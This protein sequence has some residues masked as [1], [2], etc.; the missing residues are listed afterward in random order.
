MALKTF[1][2]VSLFSNCGAG[3]TGFARAG[4]RFA[5]MAELD[6]RRLEVCQ[7][8]HPTSVTVPGDLRNTW[9]NVVDV[10]REAIDARPALLAACPPCQ[11]MSSARSYRGNADDPDAGMKDS[12]NLLVTVISRVV[13]ELK[14]RC[15]V[16]ENVPAFLSRQVRHPKNG[17][18]ITASRWLIDELSG[19]YQVF[20]FLTDL[21]DYGV[22]QTRKRIFLT[23]MR[24]DEPAVDYLRKQGATPYPLPL[25]SPEYGGH[26]VTIREALDEYKLPPLDAGSRETAISDAGNGLHA[27]PIWLDRRYDMVS[28]IPP[29]SGRSAWQN[30]CCRDCGRVEVGPDDSTCPR[31]GEP[32]LRP[33]IKASESSYRLIS[34]FRSS[35]YARMKSNAPAA[36]ITTASGHIGSNRTIHPYENRLMST[37]ECALLQTL[38]LD[39]KWGDALKRWGHSNIRAMIGE[40]VPP[41]FTVLHG[42]VLLGLLKGRAMARLY[43]DTGTRS[44]RPSKK[45]AIQSG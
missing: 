41:L 11:G 39:F 7:L 4:F 13:G 24:R 37:L 28:A 31:C 35:T 25:F 21:R 19:E 16:V 45:L 38:P 17:K 26:P 42:K 27:V 32:L 18:S 2:G 29:D 20:P 5:V 8:N 14:P 34:G 40:A 1:H 22:P 23:F 36:T 44:S 43:P 3:D 12:R 33:V 30:D 6:P 15:V 10:Y 9:P